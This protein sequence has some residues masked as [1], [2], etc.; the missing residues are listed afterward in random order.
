VE[1]LAKL[2]EAVC[3]F[4]DEVGHG[5]SRRFRGTDIFQAV[6]IRPALKPDVVAEKSG[7]ASISVGLHEF[8]RK[9]HMWCGIDIWNRRCDVSRRVV[10]WDILV[11][12]EY[13][14]RRI[15]Q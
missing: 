14:S 7:M 5:A 3:I 11:E 8:E 15:D 13:P 4:A 12:V 9:T 1:A 2:F 10:H 6:I